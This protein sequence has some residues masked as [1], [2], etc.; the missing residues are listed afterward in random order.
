VSSLLDTSLLALGGIAGS[1]ACLVAWR[2]AVMR[3]QA[4][5]VEPK[6][7]DTEDDPQPPPTL[8]PRQAPSPLPPKL[9]MPSLQP[10][11]LGPA[12]L[13]GDEEGTELI[14]TGRHADLDRLE[15]TE[16]IH[17]ENTQDSVVTAR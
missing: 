8:V 11:R 17:D 3:E 12:V 13:E 6:Y 9:R 15:I 2:H 14:S 1:I 4:P 7:D 16:P 5:T 10:I